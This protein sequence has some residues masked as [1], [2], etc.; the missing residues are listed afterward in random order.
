MDNIWNNT[1]D[2]WMSLAAVKT[3]INQTTGVLPIRLGIIDH[4]FQFWPQKIHSQ[5]YS[6]NMN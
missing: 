2:L 6:K 1:P 4:I 3:K 5:K